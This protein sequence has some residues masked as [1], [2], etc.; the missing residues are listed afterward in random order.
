M[1]SKAYPKLH[2][3]LYPLGQMPKLNESKRLGF[4]FKE[5]MHSRMNC[6]VV[7]TGEFRKPK[8]GEWYLSGAIPEG[9]RMEKDSSL[10]YHICRLVRVETKTVVVETIIAE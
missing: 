7:R 5:G 10:E 6:R 4:T 8:A 3:T 2:P 1:A 9:Y